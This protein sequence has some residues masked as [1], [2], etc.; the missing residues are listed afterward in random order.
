M[1]VGRSVPQTTMISKRGSLRR[2]MNR[3]VWITLTPVILLFSI[4]HVFPIIYG[5]TLSF[6]FYEPLT[7]TLDFAGLQN[8][9][10][11]YNNELFL[12]SLRNTF[13][14]VVIAV[15]A[16]IIIT[17]LLAVLVNSFINGKWQSIF[18]SV[19]FLPVVAPLVGSAIVWAYIYG[20]PNGLFNLLVNALGGTPQ[21][22]LA[23]TQTAMLAIIVMVIWSD[24]GYNMILFI[25]GLN[26]VPEMF[27]EAARVEGAGRLRIFFMITLPLI[28][29]T[30]LFVFIMTVL[31]YFQEFTR[32]AVMNGGGPQNSTRLISMEIYET[33]F[34]KF[35]MSSG[36]AMA[37]VLFIIMLTITIVQLRLGKSRW[38]Y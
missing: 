1:S 25:A 13:L 37:I 22:W 23:N 11:L 7:Q 28:S 34:K 29:R 21:Y 26:T 36:S 2:R 31:S 30:T 19:Y 8:F 4:F 32:F 33:A 17:L 12:K 9:K 6:N 10:N 15:P 24:I 14:F 35:D 16:N 20:Y 3:F 38:E 18:R 5:F 27:Y